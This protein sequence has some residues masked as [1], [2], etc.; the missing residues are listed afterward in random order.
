M[1]MTKVTSRA[2]GVD[3]EIVR[4]V[5]KG[6]SGVAMKLALK[7]KGADWIVQ[8]DTNF[9][10][11]TTFK[12]EIKGPA[13]RPTLITASGPGKDGRIL[14]MKI[15]MTSSGMKTEV[16]DVNKAGK[17]FGK[18]ITTQEKINQATFDKVKKLVKFRSQQ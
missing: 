4:Y 16:T 8:T 6:M 15:E 13:S 17:T 5:P 10:P 3:H 11:D 14:N 12:A 1:I 9:S 7:K 2:T 18:V